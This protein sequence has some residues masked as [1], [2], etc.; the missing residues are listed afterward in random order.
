MS[1]QIRQ[2]AASFSNRVR[3]FALPAGV[4]A[5]WASLVGLSL[6]AMSGT[7]SLSQSIE[8]VLST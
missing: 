2:A 4:V 1:S 3:A 8:R 5:I 6:A 7:S